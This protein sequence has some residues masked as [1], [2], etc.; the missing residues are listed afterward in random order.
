MAEEKA[1]T[2][3]LQ[4]RNERFKEKVRQLKAEQKWTKVESDRAKA[5]GLKEE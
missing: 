2:E 5:Y 3:R 4:K 1:V